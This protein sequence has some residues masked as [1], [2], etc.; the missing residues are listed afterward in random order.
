MTRPGASCTG[1]RHCRRRV[2]DP[3]PELRGTPA[4]A[5]GCDQGAGG[6]EMLGRREGGRE[7]ALARTRRGTRRHTA[8]WH[9]GRNLWGEA[10]RRA[11]PSHASLRHHARPSLRVRFRLRQCVRTRMYFVA[12]CTCTLP[13]QLV[14]LLCARTR[15]CAWRM[16]YRLALVMPCACVCVHAFVCARAAPLVCDPPCAHPNAVIQCVCV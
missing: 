4:D 14:C 9:L 12:A 8:G 10:L 1:C 6:R 5:P 11:L 16:R 2:L 13:L 7:R 15:T 3:R